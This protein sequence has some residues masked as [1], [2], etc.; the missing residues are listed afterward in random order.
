MVQPAVKAVRS[1]D[2]PNSRTLLKFTLAVSQT[3]PFAALAKGETPQEHQLMPAELI[4]PL[5]TFALG[6]I[7]AYMAIYFDIRKSTNQE[8][9]KKRIIVYDDLAPKLNDLLCHFT[10][11]GN[12]KAITPDT[13]TE[14]K[15]HLDRQMYI[16]GR[17]F[18]K[19]L[20]AQYQVFIHCCF[21][22]FEGAGVP[23]KIR[24]DLGFLKSNWGSAWQ[25]S[26]DKR[27]VN[28]N[29]TTAKEK[30]MNEYQK[31]ASLFARDVGA[32]SEIGCGWKVYLTTK[33]DI[34]ETT[35]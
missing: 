26:W 5:L 4:T 29:E 18:S 6:V 15:R 12:W 21:S 10:C 17:F 13:V 9:I 14:H 7:A 23:A 22:T 1:Q 25:N 2:M 31:L 34:E 11:V 35:G 8:L 28:A 27:Y 24:A 20:W 3:Y 33:A 19:E 30:I 32:A 16:Y